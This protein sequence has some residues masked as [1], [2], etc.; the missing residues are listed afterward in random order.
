[1]TRILFYISGHGYGHT[2]RCVEVMR[3]LQQ[4]KPATEIY[5]NTDAPAWLFSLNLKAG[6]TLIPK[7]CD[8][9]AVQRDSFDV[10]QK[11]TLQQFSDFYQTMESRV[12]EEIAT[13]RRLQIQVVVGDIPPLAFLAARQAG[14][15]S[16]A[17]ANFSWDWIY[18]PYAERYPEFDWVIDAIRA[19]YRQ[20]DLLLRLPFHGDL[21]AFPHFIDIPLIARKAT[22]ERDELRNRLGI[23]PQTK[24][25]LVALRSPDLARVRLDR[26]AELPDY[27]FLF[28]SPI[29]AAANFLSVPADG[30]PFQ[31]LVA[32]SDGVVSKPGYGIVSECLANKTP[33]FYTARQNFREYEVL[34]Q[35]VA[36][37]GFGKLIPPPDFFA[38]EWQEHL[39]R[40]NAADIHWPDIDPDGA[41]ITAARILA[42]S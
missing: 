35:G 30:M 38:G 33:L 32:V 5:I 26:L 21:S 34:A 23:A 2:T 42:L 29:I 1:M 20:A 6:Y 11:A 18:Q 36:E 13:I 8:V 31:N 4:L 19:A 9:G 14:V 41:E 7:S 17:I 12:A 39:K 16:V 28:F 24:L 40:L 15:P 3:C 25:I 37:L 10:D 22:L 27:H